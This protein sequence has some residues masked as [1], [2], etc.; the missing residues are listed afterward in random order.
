MTDR[1][2]TEGEEIA[3]QKESRPMPSAEHLRRRIVS[4]KKF[5]SSSNSFHFTFGCHACYLWDLITGK[6]IFPKFLRSLS[7]T[8]YQSRFTLTFF[9]GDTHFTQDIL[10]ADVLPNVC[11]WPTFVRNE[12]N[13]RR[14]KKESSPLTFYLCV[15][16]SFSAVSPF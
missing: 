3:I 13:P 16:F 7:H 10:S 2:Q 9:G 4:F 5:L 8:H 6:P 14:K 15:S 11:S 1:R 12:T